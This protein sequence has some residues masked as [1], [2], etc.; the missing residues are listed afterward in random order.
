MRSS[1]KIESPSTPPG[2]VKIEIDRST[3]ITNELKKIVYFDGDC[4]L[5]VGMDNIDVNLHLLNN[6]LVM[7]FLVDWTDYSDFEDFKDVISYILETDIRDNKKWDSQI[8]LY[9]TTRGILAT[10]KSKWILNNMCKFVKSKINEYEVC[11]HSDDVIS[12]LITP[13]KLT[14]YMKKLDQCVDGD[15]YIIYVTYNNNNS[16][17]IRR[18]N[19][20]KYAEKYY[21]FINSNKPQDY[22]VCLFDVEEDKTIKGFIKS[23]EYD[24]EVLNEDVDVE[25]YLSELVINNNK[26]YDNNRVLKI[27]RSLC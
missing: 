9:P 26:L 1:L 7:F 3:V 11:V 22:H 2:N 19:S 18:L 5:R 20:L 16:I 14:G 10:T 17:P 8:V 6:G 27:I 23:R 15:K 24:Y 12:E 21:M 25:K 4:N 13:A